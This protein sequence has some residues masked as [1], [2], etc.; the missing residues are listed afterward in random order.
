M[1][2]FLKMDDKL[3]LVCF[4]RSYD[5]IHIK[6]KRIHL[7]SSVVSSSYGFD[8]NDID[9]SFLK[10]KMERK[11]YR[12]TYYVFNVVD[13]YA[14]KENL[15]LIDRLYNIDN[16]G[17]TINNYYNCVRVI[18]IGIN[19]LLTFLEDDGNKLNITNDFIT[20][21][22]GDIDSKKKNFDSICQ[23]SVFIF[24]NI[25]WSSIVL[26]FKLKGIDIS[27]G[28][29]SKRHIL[30][31]V[32]ATLKEFLDL[33]YG[34]N[35]DFINKYI[36]YE[37]FKN[38]N[39]YLSSFINLDFYKNMLENNK[40]LK[41]FFEETN[42]CWKDIGKIS[43][44][45]SKYQS[46][47]DLFDTKYL[48]INYILIFTHLVKILTVSFEEKK[49]NYLKKKIDELNIFLEKYKRE[50]DRDINIIDYS[51]KINDEVGIKQFDENLSINLNSYSKIENEIK[52]LNEEIS[53]E[54]I[55]IDDEIK[56]KNINEVYEMVS[57]LDTVKCKI[58]NRRNIK[59]M[60]PRRT[61]KQNFVM[62]KR[63]Y[64]TFSKSSSNVSPTTLL[65]ETGINQII[66]EITTNPMYVKI[67]QILKSSVDPS[68]K[69]P[70]NNREK[71]LQIE[72]T[73]RFF[74]NQELSKVF[75]GKKSLFSNSIGINILMNSIS[76]LDKVLNIIKADKRY[77]KNKNYR[78]YIMLSENGIIVSI[79]LSN[80][81]PHMM[82]YKSSQ[83]TATLF[84]RIGM[85]L[86][87]NLLNNEWY[88]YD[89][90]KNAN[91]LHKDYYIEKNNNKYYIEE[92]LSKEDFYKRLDDILGIISSDDYFKLGC[93][94]AEI[95]S[96]NSNLFNFMNVANE[97]NTVQR[98]VVPGKK[99]DDQIVKLLAVDTEKLVMICEPC[100]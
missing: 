51:K 35:T 84:K 32:D 29:N 45:I 48:I 4:A 58:K 26:L 41:D 74:W 14:N 10:E 27:G 19:S 17:V 20:D 95:V 86:H 99:L 2:K 3:L 100:K 22:F 97:D 34:Y 70:L 59:N 81:I 53:K 64:S 96:E 7:V 36:I 79:V 85:D 63:E 38:K 50:I 72:E 93:D 46:S 82:K 91:I 25:C 69:E 68:V 57:K 88:K 60:Y 49:I 33:F 21:I 80:I 92:G 67:S 40:N 62:A 30:S 54:Y 37:S 75:E 16:R 42:I 71:Q 90:N 76:K 87:S 66:K 78:N 1:K 65:E 28:S 6:S 13:E 43:K 61:K 31:T 15:A 24:R 89:N 5:K 18:N 94:L 77:L 9:Y 52:N 83:N 8:L 39:G 73:L 56:D 98:V 23:D 55:K 11:M 44:G 12:S 47:D